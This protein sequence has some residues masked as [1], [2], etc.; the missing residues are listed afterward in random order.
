MTTPSAL[1]PEQ[2][3]EQS[4]DGSPGPDAEQERAQ[5]AAPALDETTGPAP[6]EAAVAEPVIAERDSEP[7]AERTEAEL[8]TMLGLG[9]VGA[10]MPLG[11]RARGWI[12]TGVVG[13][14]AALL[15]LIGLNHPKTLM[16]DEIL[17]RQGRLLPVAPGL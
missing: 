14:I 10:V 12:V 6:V 4:R 7:A 11:G 9:P 15:R 5:D 2:S 8:R 17:L 13:V 16:F 3:P 1:S